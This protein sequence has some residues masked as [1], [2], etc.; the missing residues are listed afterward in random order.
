MVSGLDAWRQ[1]KIRQAVRRST[2][3]ASE[4]SYRV[5]LC[6]VAPFR[7]NLVVSEAVTDKLCRLREL[8]RPLDRALVA[9]SGGVDS[10]LLTRVA[11]EEL[12]S[13]VEAVTAVSPSLPAFE[14]EAACRLAGEIGIAHRL[15]ETAEMESPDYAANGPDR[16]YHCKKE[17]F[18]QMDVLSREAAT[19]ILLYG[20]IGDDFLEYRPGHRAAG[21]ARAR[22]PLAELGY[23]KEEVRRDACALGLEVWDKPAFACLASRVPH[24]TPVTLEILAQI[25][26]GE[27]CLRE[28]GFTQFRLRHHGEVARIE[29]DP[30]ELERAVS[31]VVREEITR[32]LHGVGY[33]F[34]ALDLDGYRTG[35]L[36]LSTGSPPI[37]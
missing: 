1:S 23:T 13:R 32:R 16:C 9:F 33:R 15:V 10:A 17:L 12:G 36:T 5:K 34:V 7:G 20:A 25:E 3:A 14:R 18:A 30:V 22:A 21:E 29:L 19:A 27:A 37:S 4:P 26:Q 2:G 6:P 31:P 24:G 28:L 35:S 8:L 11:F